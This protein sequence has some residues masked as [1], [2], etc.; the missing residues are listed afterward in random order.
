MM[1]AGHR[2]G[3]GGGGGGGGT[4]KAP[5]LFDGSVKSNYF[6]LQVATTSNDTATLPSGGT[7]NGS[8]IIQLTSDPLGI[9]PSPTNIMQFHTTTADNNS[10]HT[11]LQAHTNEFLVTDGSK[12]YWLRDVIGFPASFPTMDTD[13]GAW[14]SLGS[15]YGPPHAGASTAVRQVHN[16]YGDGQNN[17][18]API[19]INGSYGGS[20]WH[21]PA[22]KNQYHKIAYRVHLAK[23][24]TGWLEIYYAPWGSPLAIQTLGAITGA[25]RSNGNTRLN[26]TTVGTQ[27]N[28]GNNDFRIAVYKDHPM[29]N[30][31]GFQDVYH[32]Y[33]GVIDDDQVSGGNPLAVD[34]DPAF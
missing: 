23:D 4:A 30:F 19:N 25:T 2:R 22:T 6:Q 24:S 28:T 12:T 8:N 10:G 9:L 5:L 11:R 16:W 1:A 31:N 14:M 15:Y 18:D 13:S 32:A 21:T 20:A 29:T 7:A 17:F 34:P 26:F 33:A 3:G 27:Q